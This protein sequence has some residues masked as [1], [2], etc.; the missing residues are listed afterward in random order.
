MRRW[1][2]KGRVD[3]DYV[4]GGNRRKAECGCDDCG[5]RKIEIAYSGEVVG[6]W[7]CRT[8]W[9]AMKNETCGVKWKIGW[10]GTKIGW[11][12]G[13]TGNWR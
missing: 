4:A 7:E 8:T 5:R 12:G 1:N 11:R 3:T 10:V 13:I 6:F 9:V 2:K